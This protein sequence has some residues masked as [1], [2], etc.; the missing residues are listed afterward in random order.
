M[1]KR[2]AREGNA[3]KRFA[4]YRR[5]KNRYEN[6]LKKIRKHTV[7]SRIKSIN[8]G[9]KEI[10]AP[11]ILSFVNNP[12]EVSRFIS[13]LRYFQEKRQPVFVVLKHVKKIDYDG[14]TVLLSAVVRFKARQIEFNGDLPDDGDA[15][16]IILESGFVQYLNDQFKDEDQYELEAKKIYTH[17][18]KSVDSE[19]GQKIIESATKTIWGMPKRCTGV[20]RV[21]VELMQNTNNHASLESSGEKHWWLSVKHIKEEKKATFSFIDYGV[22]VFNSLKNKKPGNKFYG[23]IEKLYSKV[24]STMNG[25]RDSDVLRLIFEGE[26]HRTVTGKSYR[27]KGLPGIYQAFQQNRISNLCMITNNVMFSSTKNEYSALS[28]G[29]DGTFV[30]WELHE[31]NLHLD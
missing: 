18:Q 10:K 25:E 7:K 4:N 30:Y 14:I 8:S 17:A 3:R 20:Q 31:N 24:I 9:Y 5:E 15:Y 29:F 13:T 19:L 11:E 26:L 23:A 2:A 1:Q 28:N 12:E 6:S 27:G 22:G 21:F 16:K